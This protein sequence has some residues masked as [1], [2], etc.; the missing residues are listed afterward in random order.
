MAHNIGEKCVLIFLQYNSPFINSQTKSKVK[1][2]LAC[3]TPL[4][5]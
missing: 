4:I 1:S 2:N 5:H 3:N